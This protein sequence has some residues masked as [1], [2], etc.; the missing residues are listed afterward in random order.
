M[1][2]QAVNGPD[3]PRGCPVAHGAGDGLTRLYGPEAATDPRGIYERLREEHG[4]VA[5]VLLEGDVPAWLVLGYRDNRRVLDTPRQ[6]TRDARIWRDWREGRVAD[7]SPIMPMVGW[8]P[9]CVSQDGEPHR[10]L[11]GAV[12]D[13]LLAASGRGCGGTRRTSPTS[14]STR[15]WTPAGPTWSRTMPSICRCWC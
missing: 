7:T 11:R 8:R 13:G 10:R 3:A 4:S 15:S 5:P 1:T 6:F 14:R 9:D 2:E 12:T